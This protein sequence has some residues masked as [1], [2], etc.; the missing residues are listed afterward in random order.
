MFRIERAGTVPGKA[1]T[2]TLRQQT[3]NY[4]LQHAC[5]IQSS[6]CAPSKSNSKEDKRSPMALKIGST[7]FLAESTTSPVLASQPRVAQ[8]PFRSLTYLKHETIENRQQAKHNER[9]RSHEWCST[10][11]FPFRAQPQNR[12]W[13]ETVRP[14]R[15]RCFHTSALPYTRCKS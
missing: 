11:I 8:A 1:Y 10:S 4:C 7:Q 2:S 6:S 3:K 12:N 5:N 9:P 13:T 14:T 15:T